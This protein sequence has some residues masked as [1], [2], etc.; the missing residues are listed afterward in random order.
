MKLKTTVG[1]GVAVVAGL[2]VL[3]GMTPFYHEGRGTQRSPESVTLDVTWSVSGG[4]TT[5]TINWY[6]TGV[7]S[8]EETA[9]GGHWRRDIRLPGRGTYIVTLTGRPVPIKREG[10]GVTALRSATSTCTIIRLAGEQRNVHPAEP[11]K[12]CIVTDS[13]LVP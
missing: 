9:V 3:S 1:A 4:V 6:Y 11:G 13:V 12:G 5:A 7:K 2:A 10:K 8:K